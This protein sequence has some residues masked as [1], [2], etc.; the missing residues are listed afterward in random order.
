M[1]EMPVEL[2]GTVREDGTL[3]LDDKLSLPA[4]RVKVTV[5]PMEAARTFYEH[6]LE[7]M[8]TICRRQE[9]RGYV[10]PSVDEI[11]SELNALRDE[12][13][14]EFRAIE[15]LQIDAETARRGQMQRTEQAD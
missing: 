1:N 12:A 7:T 2:E 15:Q 13:E 3:E 5:Q 6:L 11:D 10:P 4:G 9:T 14:E 8:E